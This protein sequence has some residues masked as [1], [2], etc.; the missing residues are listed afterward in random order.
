MKRSPPRKQFRGVTGA[1]T[2]RSDPPP[3]GFSKP[4]SLTLA[5]GL[6]VACVPVPAPRLALA[7]ALPHGPG[8]SLILKPQSKP[9]VTCGLP[10]M[11]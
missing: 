11:C 1:R 8:V 5:L 4:Q 10:Y 7:L 6:P 3:R 9:F 2:T